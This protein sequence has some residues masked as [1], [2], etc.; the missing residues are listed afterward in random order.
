MDQNPTDALKIEEEYNKIDE[1]LHQHNV[2]SNVELIKE[3]HVSLDK[4]VNI[5]TVMLQ[6]LFILVEWVVLN[7]WSLKAN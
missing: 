1:I 5:F 7:S 3:F 2:R 4:F 6:I